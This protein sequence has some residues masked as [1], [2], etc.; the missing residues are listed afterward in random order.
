[1]G[2]GETVLLLGESGSG[3][4]TLLSLICGTVLPQEGVVEV[5]GTN[6]C[7]LPGGLRDRFRAEQIG[8]IFQQFNLLPFGTVEDNILLPL[9]FAPERR[10]RAGN[11]HETATSL[12][13]NL[14]LPEP[15]MSA[16]ASTLSVGQ[17]QRVAVAR[18]LIGKP[19]II[20]ADEPTSSLDEG[21]QSTFL[22]LLFD[23]VT[24]NNA[25]LLMVSHD[26]RLA[27][28]FDKTIMLT[29]IAKIER[30]PQ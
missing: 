5:A 19:P 7:K 26:P 6:V 12:A 30:Q 20:I 17:Q 13:R 22:D 11:A 24:T 25:T 28:R 8:I 18:A 4:S 29:D 21:S 2:R 10:S 27:A 3:K 14:G 23:Q 16:R 15:L 1:M 9:S